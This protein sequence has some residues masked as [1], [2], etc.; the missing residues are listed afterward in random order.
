MQYN[1]FIHTAKERLGVGSAEEVMNIARAF[2]H[3]LTDHMAGNAADNLAAQLPA[4]L[5]HLIREI[6]PE[7]RDQGERFKLPEFYER[8]SNRAGVGADKGQ[9]YTQTLM[10]LLS[11]MVTEGEIIKIRKILSADYA[12]LFSGTHSQDAA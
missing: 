4:E 3:T 5:A 6:N 9:K 7:D 2:F 11:Q 10:T 1:E 12:E 8:V